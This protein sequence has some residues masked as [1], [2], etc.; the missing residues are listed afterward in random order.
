MNASIALRLARASALA[1][2]VL[3]RP[4]AVPAA[5]RLARPD[6]DPQEDALSND[7]VRYEL[8]DHVAQVTLH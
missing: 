6:L 7:L 3:T 4:R 5:C 8:Q 2:R 1:E